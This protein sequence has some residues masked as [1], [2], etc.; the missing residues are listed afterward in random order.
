MNYKAVTFHNS[1]HTQI[2]GKIA[3]RAQIKKKH[4]F[5]FW[6]LNE[7]PTLLHWFLCVCVS[8]CVHVCL[9]RISHG[10]CCKQ[11]K[12]N[13][14]PKLLFLPLNNPHIKYSRRQYIKKSTE[15]AKNKEQLLT[16]QQIYWKFV[17]K[18][19]NNQIL[20]CGK[21]VTEVVHVNSCFQKI[22]VNSKSM[23]N[24]ALKS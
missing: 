14:L 2:L 1:G 13:P 17:E 3:T 19:L 6:Q 15:N 10:V 5:H 24:K 22:A 21:T 18:T 11:G 4:L 12:L 7:C 20:W 16:S 9:G 23:V 8:V